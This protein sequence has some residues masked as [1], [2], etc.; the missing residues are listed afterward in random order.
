MLLVINTIILV[1]LAKGIVLFK[2]ADIGYELSR[3]CYRK[4]IS[5]VN[6]I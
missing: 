1:S 3:F 2:S 4:M 6:Y 5:S